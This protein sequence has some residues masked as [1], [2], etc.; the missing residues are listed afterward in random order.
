[1]QPGP[2]AASWRLLAVLGPQRGPGGGETQELRAV[3]LYHTD[4]VEAWCMTAMLST[5]GR[6]ARS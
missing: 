1:M 2:W 3:M 4:G 5:L 6:E